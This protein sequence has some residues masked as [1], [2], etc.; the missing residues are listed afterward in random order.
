MSRESGACQR[1][2]L[3]ESEVAF[4]CIQNATN[5]AVDFAVEFSGM[6]DQNYIDAGQGRFFAFGT[7]DYAALQGI[8]WGNL[9]KNAEDLNF[10]VGSA[11][12]VNHYLCERS[13][14]VFT[15]S[16]DGVLRLQ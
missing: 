14:H 10:K 4:I 6:S 15:Y 13:P 1:Q 11:N 2:V 9:Y 16:Q 7:R 5:H 12:A 8:S 3:H